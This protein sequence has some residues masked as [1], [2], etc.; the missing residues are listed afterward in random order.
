MADVSLLHPILLSSHP[1][2]HPSSHLNLTLAN[3]FDVVLLFH[4]RS[5]GEKEREREDIVHSADRVGS[6]TTIGL[7]PPLVRSKKKK[8]KKKLD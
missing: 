1:S 3:P 6:A 4:N 5:E 7:I 8:K 2:I